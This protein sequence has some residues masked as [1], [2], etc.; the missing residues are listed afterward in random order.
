MGIL[1]RKNKN[2]KSKKKKSKSKSKKSKRKSGRRNI[3]FDEKKR[4]FLD[5]FCNNKNNGY[6]KT[7]FG[8]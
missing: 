1:R 4:L 8:T 2:K 6:Y 7:D 5:Y 3:S